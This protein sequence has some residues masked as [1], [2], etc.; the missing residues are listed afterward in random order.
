MSAGEGDSF[1]A[2]DEVGI[3]YRR[4]DGTP[5]GTPVML[6]HGFMSHGAL[7]WEAT[8]VVEALTAVA[9][10]VVTLDARGHGRS[11]KPT[12]PAAFGEGRMAD[13]LVELCDHLNL[14]RFDVVGYS[15]GGL[16]ALL[17]AEE[18]PRVRRL[19][20]GGLGAKLVE[21]GLEA[22]ATSGPEVAEALE[23]DDPDTVT[24]PVA[25][26]FR[27]FADSVDADRLALAAHVRSVRRRQIELDAIRVPTLVLAGDADPL[28][29]DPDVLA[30][31]LPD[32]RLVVVPGDHLRAVGSA[33]FRR[34]LVEFLAAPQVDSSPR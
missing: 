10:P 11:D 16:V 12:E 34:A 2:S 20:V 9:G 23:A 17:V 15:M 29:R 1:T 5:G 27:A 7:N 18:D 22:M 26:S 3:H 14:E 30:D 31:A 25:R 24:D 28:A 8:G 6:H 19:A 32:A 33:E 21:G 13:D 4:W